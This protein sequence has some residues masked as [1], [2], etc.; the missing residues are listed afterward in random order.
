MHDWELVSIRV[1]EIVEDFELVFEPEKDPVSGVHIVAAGRKQQGDTNLKAN[2]Q[3]TLATI[4]KEEYAEYQISNSKDCAGL[5]T[6][7]PLECSDTT[8]H[9]SPDQDTAAEEE[10]H[11]STKLELGP[12]QIPCPAEVAALDL[13]VPKCQGF[14]HQACSAPGQ[15]A[16]LKNLTE[17]MT[18]R[19]SRRQRRVRLLGG[20]AV[21]S[22][23][24]VAIGLA[25]GLIGYRHVI[26]GAGP[27]PTS[28]SS[29]INQYSFRL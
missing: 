11:S 22:T 8:A 23:I 24:M 28:K 2:D 10:V 26:Q 20:A 27:A 4:P 25:T 9:V 17:V 21:S 12:C 7:G 13:F 16:T 6:S 1:P 15:D 3:E 29:A 19:L 14:M 5:S 18:S